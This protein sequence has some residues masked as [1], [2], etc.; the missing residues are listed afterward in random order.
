MNVLE[1]LYYSFDVPFLFYLRTEIS[2][3]TQDYGVFP[4]EQTVGERK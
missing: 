2:T 3:N 1:V 4:Y